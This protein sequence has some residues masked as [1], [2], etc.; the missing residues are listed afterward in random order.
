MAAKNKKARKG[1]ACVS[2]PRVS[3]HRAAAK[4]R[5]GVTAGMSALSVSEPKGKRQKIKHV[6]PAAAASA[7]GAKKVWD[8]D[9]ACKCR[10]RAL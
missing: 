5:L 7:T 10:W 4:S 1:D 8:M 2:N 6:A 9:D 3:K